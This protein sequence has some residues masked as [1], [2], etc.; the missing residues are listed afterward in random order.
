MDI[1][2]KISLVDSEIDRLK[3]RLKN[4][5][6]ASRVVLALSGHISQLP[7]FQQF[8]VLRNIRHILEVEH[9]DTC[10]WEDDGGQ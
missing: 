9:A 10:R 3:Q 7:S 5:P 6:T 1:L 8:L 4:I 2:D